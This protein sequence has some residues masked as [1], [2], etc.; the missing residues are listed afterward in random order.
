MF[1][2]ASHVLAEEHEKRLFVSCSVI[3]FFKVCMSVSMWYVRGIRLFWHVID[4]RH[5]PKDTANY[6]DMYVLYGIFW[7]LFLVSMKMHEKNIETMRKK[8]QSLKLNQ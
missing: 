7:Q 4:V 2:E 5:F 3:V 8:N 6:R 1:R